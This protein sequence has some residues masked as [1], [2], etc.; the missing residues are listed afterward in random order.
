MTDLKTHPGTIINILSMTPVSHNPVGYSDLQEDTP[1]IWVAM[2][3][4][5]SRLG[6]HNT[7]LDCSSRGPGSLPCN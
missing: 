2:V 1:F 3:K 5:V 4:A 7:R 6:G